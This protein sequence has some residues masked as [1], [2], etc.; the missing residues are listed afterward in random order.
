MTYMLNSIKAI[1]PHKQ[2][3]VHLSVIKLYEFA[4]KKYPKKFT[5]FD[6]VAFEDF[7]DLKY[8]SGLINEHFKDIKDFNPTVCYHAG[9]SFKRKNDNCM[10]AIESGTK[11]IG[12]GLNILRNP[13]AIELVKQKG[14]TIES[15]PLSNILLGY[16]NDLNWH[17]VKFLKDMGVK[18]RYFLLKLLIL[19]FGYSYI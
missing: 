6:F 14:I 8:Y 1:S 18:I 9:E 15:C 4:A 19:V 12:H 10:N 16:V 17:P 7:D 3:D 13:K 11:R 5:A 2:K